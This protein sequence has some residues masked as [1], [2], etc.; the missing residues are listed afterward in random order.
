MHSQPKVSQSVSLSY[1]KIFSACLSVI[2]IIFLTKIRV[3][4][5][6]SNLESLISTWFELCGEVIVGIEVPIGTS[7]LS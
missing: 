5:E 6:S 7:I 1:E 2:A 3:T 4:R